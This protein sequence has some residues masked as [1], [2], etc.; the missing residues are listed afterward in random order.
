MDWNMYS[1]V[2]EDLARSIRES[3]IIRYRTQTANQSGLLD[4]LQSY[5]RNW[6]RWV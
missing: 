6:P 2:E 5:K 1:S 4:C 3:S